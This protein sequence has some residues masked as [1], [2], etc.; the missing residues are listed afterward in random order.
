MTKTQILQQWAARSLV[1]VQSHRVTYDLDYVGY[2]RIAWM[3]DESDSRGSNLFHLLN[4]WTMH[5]RGTNGNAVTRKGGHVVT[6]ATRKGGHVVTATT[7][8]RFYTGWGYGELDEQGQCLYSLFVQTTFPPSDNSR[9]N[10]SAD[11]LSIAH[12]KPPGFGFALF[13][14]SLKHILVRCRFHKEEGYTY[15]P[16]N[17]PGRPPWNTTYH[18]SPGQGDSALLAPGVASEYSATVSNAD[19][20]ASATSFDAVPDEFAGSGAK[21]RSSVARTGVTECAAKP[22]SCSLSSLSSD[23]DTSDEDIKSATLANGSRL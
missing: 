11:S 1:Y 22:I 3:P 5:K 16:K 20:K 10:K 9:N 21:G 8:N 6:A 15:T 7:R 2:F 14:A 4:R 18:P 12:W 23:E 17:T 19:F 13:S